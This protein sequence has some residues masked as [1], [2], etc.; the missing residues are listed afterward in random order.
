MQTP[1]PRAVGPSEKTRPCATLAFC[2][3]AL[4]KGQSHRTILL[5]MPIDKDNYAAERRLQVGAALLLAVGA[6]VWI[7][8]RAGVHRVFVPG[9]WRF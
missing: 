3:T 7:V 5:L 8:L 6:L 1:A 2:F 9:W 4:R